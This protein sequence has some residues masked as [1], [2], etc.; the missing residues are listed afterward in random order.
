MICVCFECTYMN[1]VLISTRSFFV[2]M[3]QAKQLTTHICIKT[4]VKLNTE[5]TKVYESMRSEQ[6]IKTFLISW[7]SSELYCSN[8]KILK[9]LRMISYLALYKYNNQ[10]Q[11]TFTGAPNLNYFAKLY[12]LPRL[13]TCC[14]TIPR[15]LMNSMMYTY[16]IEK[17]VWINV[18][19]ITPCYDKAF[20]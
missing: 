5:F 7:S 13:H 8:T 17:L 4:P 11:L 14:L 10:M 1:T 2:S 18:L 16:T 19:I 15:N 3:L 12:F 20:F 9:I 6:L